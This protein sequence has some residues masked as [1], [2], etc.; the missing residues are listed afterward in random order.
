MKREVDLSLHPVQTRHVSTVMSTSD[1][2]KCPLLSFDDFVRKAMGSEAEASFSEFLSLWRSSESLRLHIRRFVE[3]SLARSRTDS[4]DRDE[5]DQKTS[6]RQIAKGQ[7]ED[8][9]QISTLPV[10]R[11]LNKSHGGLSRKELLIL[12]EKYKAGNRDLGIYLLVRAWKKHMACPEKLL[13]PRLRQL[14]L[15]YHGRAIA[16]NRTDFFQQITDTMEFLKDEEFRENGQ[17]NHDPGQWWQ[18]H[19]LLYVLEYPKDKYPMREFVRYFETEVGANAMPTT[20]TLRS[21]CRTV[22]IALDSRPGA[23]RKKISES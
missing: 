11:H 23:P 22:G 3:H 2:S 5:F 20:K 7:P 10:Q 8:W 14:T 16:E 21:F 4:S 13:D 19:L 18:F 6:G 9:S 1:H 17:W 12:L 15:D